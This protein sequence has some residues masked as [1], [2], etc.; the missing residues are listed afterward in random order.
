MAAKGLPAVLALSPEYLKW[1]ADYMRSH[2]KEIVEH[3]LDH[4]NSREIQSLI[5]SD[6]QMEKAALDHFKD[7]DAVG[8]ANRKHSLD[9][10]A[11]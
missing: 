8:K 5:A 3:I 11:D 1:R 7:F 2:S 9:V 6:E 10:F 4:S